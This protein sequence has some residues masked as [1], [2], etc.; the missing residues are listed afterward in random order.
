MSNVPRRLEG[1][2]A[3]V[4]GSS[5]GIGRGI[6]I[7]FAR[8]GANVAINYSKSKESADNTLSEV[9][10]TG[11]K[12]I[13]I[14]ADVSRTEQ[15]DRMV[16]ETIHEFGRLDI[17]VNNAG[18]FIEKSLEETTDEIWDTIL[19]VNLKGAFLCAR[20]CVPEMVRFGKG[21]IINTASMDGLIAEPNIPADCS[22][23][24]GIIGLTTSLAL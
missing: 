7:R 17:L 5:S 1:K 16:S 23:K 22:S 14:R 8:E 12:G 18:V 20:R 10:A 21:K 3:L 15:V 9:K 4:T 6:T 13:A 24:A 19:G 2:S 11:A